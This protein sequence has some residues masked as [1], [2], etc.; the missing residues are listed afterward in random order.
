MNRILSFLAVVLLVASSPSCDGSNTAISAAHKTTHRISAHTITESVHCSGTAIGVNALLTA[1][2]CEEPTDMLTVDNEPVRVLGLIR[3]GNDHTIYLLD[4]AFA[5]YAKFGKQ[6]EVGDDI[7][8]FGNP[9]KFTDLFRRGSVAGIELEGNFLEDLLNG[10]DLPPPNTPV[11]KKFYFDFNGWPGDSG[12]A[13]F[14]QA[15]EIAGVISVAELIQ[16]K[17]ESDP[18]PIFKVMGG[19]SFGFTPAQLAQA[20]NFRAPIKP[21]APPKSLGDFSHFFKPLHP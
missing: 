3:D 12:A 10:D 11:T 4:F 9:G 17:N 20:V 19:Y 21:K 8:S 13:T 7:F 16:P 18:W 14:N 2:H 1:S 5:D 6:P 15:G